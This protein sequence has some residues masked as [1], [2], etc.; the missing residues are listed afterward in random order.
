[1]QLDYAL[2]LVETHIVSDALNDET[3]PRT[4]S[5]IIQPTLGDSKEVVPSSVQPNEIDLLTE[6]IQSIQTENNI[7]L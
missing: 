7:L 2:L 5:T 3:V 1:M 6:H 4:E